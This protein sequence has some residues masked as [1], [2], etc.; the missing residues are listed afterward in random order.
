MPDS[1][2]VRLADGRIFRRTRRDINIDNSSS[3]SSTAWAVAAGPILPK[4]LWEPPLTQP[5][6]A[7]VPL[8]IP[9]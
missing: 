8:I 5:I 1:Y 3:A 9:L 2:V 6:R 7:E 4:L